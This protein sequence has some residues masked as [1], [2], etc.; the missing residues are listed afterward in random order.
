M[1]R[2]AAQPAAIALAPVT[3]TGEDPGHAPD[4]ETLL[5]TAFG[6]ERWRKTCQRLRDGN[7]AR[8]DLGLVALDERDAVI[9]T[10]RLWPVKAGRRSAL[11][12]GPLAV[13]PAWRNHGI[14]IALM[15]EAM[16]RATTA[17][18]GAILLVG[19]APYYR[20]FGFT[21]DLTRRLWLPGPVDRA[22]FLAR[23]LIP[24]ALTGA[25]GLVTPD[26]GRLR[27]ALPLAA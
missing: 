9:G 27:P 23:E 3:I 2:L 16:A 7:R 10:V 20:R 4:I 6:A 8:A 15:N 12:L 14:G 25:K 24:G 18:D 26:R 5:D 22:R 13:D 17:G 11:L 1:A 19:D 21:A